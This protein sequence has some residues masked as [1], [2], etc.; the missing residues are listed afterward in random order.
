MRWTIRWGPVGWIRTGGVNSGRSRA[1]RGIAQRRSKT[2]TSPSTYRSAWSGDHSVAPWRQMSSMSVS[3]RGVSLKPPAGSSATDAA[4]PR[5]EGGRVEGSRRPTLQPLGDGRLK[6][7]H[8]AGALLVAPDQMADVVA[9]VAEAA[10]AGALLD[11]S[12]HR[13]GERDVHRGH[14]FLRGSL[15]RVAFMAILAKTAGAAEP[16]TPRDLGVTPPGLRRPSTASPDLRRS[17]GSKSRATALRTP[18][19]PPERRAAEADR[20]PDPAAERVR[21]GPPTRIRPWRSE[22]LGSQAAGRRRG[23][24][25]PWRSLVSRAASPFRLSPRPPAAGPGSSPRRPGR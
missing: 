3:A 8:G 5:L 7:R 4:H 16:K 12:L 9:G 6:L 21:G 18:T 24:R 10:V 20:P 14:G 25:S 19:C 15:V 1:R 23:P 17:R 2:A 11:P 13:I 22:R